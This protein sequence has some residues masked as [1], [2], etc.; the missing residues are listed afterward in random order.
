MEDSLKQQPK[1]APHVTPTTPRYPGGMIGGVPL[2]NRAN[3]EYIEQAN[4]PKGG[5]KK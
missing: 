2:F 1:E 5:G 3:R 4:K